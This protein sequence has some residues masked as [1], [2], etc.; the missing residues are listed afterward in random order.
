[1]LKFLPIISLLLVICKV[2][3]QNFKKKWKTKTNLDVYVLFICRDCH[4]F[5]LGFDQ[6]FAELGKDKEKGESSGYKATDQESTLQ[7]HGNDY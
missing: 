6:P 7:S 3:I 1:M 4:E 2:K 5:F